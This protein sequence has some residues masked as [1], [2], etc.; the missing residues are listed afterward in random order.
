MPGKARH[1]YQKRNTQLEISLEKSRARYE[2]GKAEDQGATIKK[3]AE[4][5]TVASGEAARSKSPG[6]VIFRDV[7]EVTRPSPGSARV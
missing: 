2:S 7:F 5:Y 6:E 3:S 1:I 4:L